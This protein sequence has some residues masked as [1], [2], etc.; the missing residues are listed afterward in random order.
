MS[1]KSSFLYNITRISIFFFFF[2]ELSKVRGTRETIFLIELLSLDK[3][4][5]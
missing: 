3:M 4:I 2:A 5:K 1:R